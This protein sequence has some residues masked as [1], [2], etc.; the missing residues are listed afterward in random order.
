MVLC[1]RYDTEHSFWCIILDRAQITEPYWRTFLSWKWNQRQWTHKIEHTGSF[2]LRHPSTCRLIRSR[3][4]VRCPLHQHTRSKNTTTHL[5]RNGIFPALHPNPCRQHDR[6][7]YRQQYHQETTVESNGNGIFLAF[8]SSV[9]KKIKFTYKPGQENLA[10][11]YTKAFSGKEMIQ[12]RPFY[13]HMKESPRILQ[14]AHLPHTRQ[15]CV[16]SKQDSLC[17]LISTYVATLE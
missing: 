11:Y 5:G 10:N 16:E 2:N 14:R 8:G 4:W 13:Q 15:G 9:T 6:D 7:R 3:G 12:Q 1:I 17:K